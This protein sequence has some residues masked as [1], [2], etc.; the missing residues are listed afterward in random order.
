MNFTHITELM[1]FIW[2][3]HHQQQELHPNHSLLIIYPR[4]YPGSNEGLVDPTISVADFHLLLLV[5]NNEQHCKSSWRQTQ[6]F[7]D[8]KSMVFF[9][10]FHT[11]AVHQD[12]NCG[13]QWTEP[14]KWK[15]RRPYANARS[16]ALIGVGTVCVEWL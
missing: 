4:Q 6:T 14:W 12:Q 2:Q 3:R 1:L 9:R 10:K 7:L 15:E 5:L 16:P 11:T 8:W 13:E